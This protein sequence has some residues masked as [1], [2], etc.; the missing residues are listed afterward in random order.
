MS[1]HQDSVVDALCEEKIRKEV[2]KEIMEK[3]K[4]DEVLDHVHEIFQY[5][6]DND[7]EDLLESVLYFIEKHGFSKK[8]L[9]DG[10]YE[11]VEAY[12]IKEAKESHVNCEASLLCA[13]NAGMGMLGYDT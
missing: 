12:Q 11:Q 9:P 10:I 13:F 1:Y 3:R 8:N 7:S 5:L 2:R 4:L 6:E